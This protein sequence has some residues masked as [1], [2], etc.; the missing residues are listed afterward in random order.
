M[1]PPVV[2]PAVMMSLLLKMSGLPSSR[3]AA[4]KDSS[5][6]A[7][8][9]GGEGDRRR[10]MCPSCG[11]FQKR[12]RVGGHVEFDFIEV[13]L[14]FVILRPLRILAFPRPH[15]VPLVFSGRTRRLNAT[16]SR[17]M[18][19]HPR[20]PRSQATNIARCPPLHLRNFSSPKPH[21]L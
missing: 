1:H 6:R 20:T 7:G 18:A 2:F 5:G 17:L 3:S 12:L 9:R 11:M 15:V 8:N 4:F 10:S 16:Q 14:F 19:P 13:S 21:T